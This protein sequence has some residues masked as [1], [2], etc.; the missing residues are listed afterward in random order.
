[1]TRTVHLSSTATYENQQTFPL[2][3]LYS[4]TH[5]YRG[6]DDGI[7]KC[8]TLADLQLYNFM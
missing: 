2:Y 1:M 4:C 5:H 8:H 7:N 6:H 3:N